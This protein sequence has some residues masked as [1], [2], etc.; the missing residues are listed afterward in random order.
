[1]NAAPSLQ[2]KVDEYI[3]ERRRLGFKLHGMAQGLAHFARYVSGVHHRGPL[4]CD[5]MANWARQDKT[6]AHKTET[7]A[8]RLQML[9]PFARWMRQFEAQTEIPDESVFGPMPGRLTPHICHE[10]EIVALLDA[11]RHMDPP[12]SLRPATFETLFGLIACAGLRVSEALNLLDSDVDLQDGTLVVRQTKFGKSRR[13]P[14]HASTVQ[15]LAHYRQLRC[16]QIGTTADTT[17]FIGTR[18]KLLGQPLGDRQVHRVF[19]EL[20]TK[21]DWANRG[22]HVTVRIHD[23]RH[24]FAVRTLM[25]WHQLGIDIDQAMLSLSTYLGHVKITHS[26]W[27][28]TSVPELMALAGAKFEQFAQVPEFGDD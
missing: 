24:T 7:S 5:L 10:T 19:I 18:G 3:T 22:A 1:M 28:L 21:L 25:R 4:T 26:Y 9:R 23:L 16:Q 6:L 14:L 13:L 8:R 2:S 27:Y 15:S 20:I 11:A 17:F 12:N